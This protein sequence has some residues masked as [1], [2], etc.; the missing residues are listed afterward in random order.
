MASSEYQMAIKIAGEIEKSFYNSTKLTKKELQGIAKTAA[1]TSGA[2]PKTFSQGLKDAEPAFTGLEN[3]AKKSFKAITAA[4]VTGGATI[5]A[6]LAASVSAGSEFESAFAGVKKTVN[7]TAPE[8]AQMRDE[9]RE[10]SKEMPTSAAGLSEIAESAGQLGIQT[11]NITK[12]TKTMADLSVATNLTSEKGAA[13]FAKFAN[14]TKMPQENFDRLGSSVVALG[15]NMATTEADIVGMGMRIAAAGDQVN[16]S[17]ADI[18]AYA[19]SLSSVGIE[20]EAGGSAFSKLLVNLQMATETGKGL[21]EYA[22]VAGMTGKEFKQAFQEDATTAI[23]SF[24]SGLNDTE[25]NGKSAIAVLDDMGLT[26]V[27]LRDTLLRAANASEMFEG[28]L[29]TSNTAW[30]EN[31]ALAKEAEQRYSTFESQCDILGNKITDI[32]ISVYDSLKPGL[33][34]AMGLANDFVDSLAG[35]EDAIGGFIDS[36]VKK[37]PTMV[38]QVKDAGKAIGDFAKPFLQVGG[39]LADNPGLLVGTI[40]GIGSALT[41]YKVASGVMSLATS[42]GALGP[43][44]MGILALG[45]VAAVIAGIGTAV[46]KS[47]NE[48]KKANLNKHFGNISLSMKDLQEVASSIVKGKNL[49]QITESITAMGE[50]DGIA[51]DIQSA[52]DALNKMNWKVSIGLEL[53]ETEEEEYR[54][55]AEEYIRAT[56]EYLEQKQFALNLSIGALSDGDLENNDLVDK[57]NRFYEGKKQELA[58][59]GTQLNDAI[60]EAFQDGLLDIDEAAEI[61]KIQQSMAEIQSAMAGSEYQAGL[62]LIGM[63]YGGQQLDADSF[64]NLQAEIQGQVDAASGKYAEAYTANVSQYGVML[65][66]GGPNGFSQEE[67]DEAVKEAKAEYLKQVAELQQQAVDFQ[68]QMIQQAY[69]ELGDIQKELESAVS[70]QTESAFKGATESG[71]YGKYIPFIG[72]DITDQMKGKVDKATQDA[73]GELFEKLQP[74]VEQLEGTKTQAIEMGAAIPE[75]VNEGIRDANAIGVLSGNTEA[76]WD[77]IGQETESDEYNGMIKAMQEAGAMIPEEFANAVKM[78]QGVVQDAVTDMYGIA[79]NAVNSAGGSGRT[80]KKS[81]SGRKGRNPLIGHAEGGIF[82]TPHIAWFAENGPESAIPLDGSKNAISLWLRTGELLGM[83]GLTGGTEPI[84]AGVGQMAAS[85]G[86]GPQFVFSPRLNFY[87]DAPAKEEITELIETE[88][89]KFER[90]MQQWIKQNGRLSFV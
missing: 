88:Q 24:L 60:T 69:P 52:A 7:A 37:M 75:G 71:E 27:R 8:L 81:T 85:S 90:N 6:G 21:S 11:E 29:E 65:E 9:I 67:Y 43:V 49:E 25:R 15:N 55:Q 38:R 12:F 87:G 84:T 74:S 63:K 62:D 18:M 39:W 42:L 64:Q 28:A 4:A 56:Q 22:K 57:V 14:I 51:E 31:T 34:E 61:A 79:E 53:T 20:A 45:G 40:V 47:A 46:K 1:Q 41:A 59:L 76:L 26:E 30:E 78:N 83:D 32:G 70:Q 77:L 5:A 16:L 86:G 33:T 36:A 82:D 66:E 54:S 23:N 89:E 35:Q 73:L 80:G 2:V 50:L 3:V 10:M 19:A 72:D 13:E 44:G 17:Q 68:I 58:A 48:A